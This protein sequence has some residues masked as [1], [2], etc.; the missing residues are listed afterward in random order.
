MLLF[1]GRRYSLKE[2]AAEINCSKQTVLRLLE[3]IRTSYS[4]LIDETTEGRQKYVRIKSPGKKPVN[5]FLTNMELTVLQMCRDFT[6]H[7]LGSKLFEEATQALL[8][9]HTLLQTDGK[10]DSPTFGLIRSGYIDYT[11]HNEIIR[12]LIEA[13][14]KK[15]ICRVTY[16]SVTSKQVKTFHINPLKIFSYRDTLYLQTQKAREPKEV[17]R[18]PD[19]D[20]L[21]AIH[22]IQKVE[23]TDRLFKYPVN[24]DFDKT[25]NQN[26]GLIKDDEFEVVIEF[27]GWAA[28]YVAD[29]IWNPDQKIKKLKGDK[30]QLTMSSSSPD[31]ILSWILFF[32]EYAKLTSP[33]WLLEGMK[34]KTQ[35]LANLY[36]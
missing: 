23:I 8:K 1:T 9:S 35:I 14:E 7:L 27:T 36:S 29:R 32:G 33:D 12:T 17:Y 5:V 26:F 28:I 4:V 30:I 21:L 2:L 22:R 10:A 6:G 18:K 34:T 24:Y 15:R 20:P 19:F 31:E 13:M 16:K 25:F 11:S 3:D